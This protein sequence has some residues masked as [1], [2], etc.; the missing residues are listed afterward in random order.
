MENNRKGYLPG[1]CIS[2]RKLKTLSVVSYDDDDG[3]IVPAPPHPF[4]LTFSKL[5]EK[6]GVLCANHKTQRNFLAAD[7]ARPQ[8]GRLGS[9]RVVYKQ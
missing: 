6:I 9:R 4:L 8:Q 3:M 5:V 2:L 7:N 1:A